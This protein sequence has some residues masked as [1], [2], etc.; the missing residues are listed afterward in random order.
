MTTSVFDPQAFL[1][2]QQTEVNERRQPLPVE[3]PAAEDGLYT[4]LIGEVKMASGTYEKGDNVGD[5]WL[6]AVVPLQIEVPP[7]LQDSLKLGKVVTLIDR[8]FIALTK[9]KTIDNSP[10]K[11]GRQKQYREALDLNKPGDVWSWRKAVG[12]VVKVKIAH[13]MYEGNVQDKP[14]TILKR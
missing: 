2:A 6:Q 1:D 8:P 5:P 7:Q 9:Q 11:N 12:Q 10:G 3:N 4:A 14:Q 13:E